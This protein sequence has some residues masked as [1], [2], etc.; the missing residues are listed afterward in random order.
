MTQQDLDIEKV[1][2]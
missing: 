1:E 2:A